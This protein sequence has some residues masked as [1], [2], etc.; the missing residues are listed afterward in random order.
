MHRARTRELAVTWTGIPSRR[1]R[2]QHERACRILRYYSC[3][4]ASWSK[5][6]LE[7]YRR[8]RIGCLIFVMRCTIARCTTPCPSEEP[9]T[10]KKRSRRRLPQA[11]NRLSN[12]PFFLPEITMAIILVTTRFNPNYLRHYTASKTYSF[13][14]ISDR[15]YQNLKNKITVGIKPFSL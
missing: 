10:R 15:I 4:H 3:A 1:W 11:P 12:L 5:N 14:I 13:D 2:A 7:Q 6:I 9:E 8:D